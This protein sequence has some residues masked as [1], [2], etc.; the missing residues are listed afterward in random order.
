VG[1]CRGGVGVYPGSNFVHVDSR[2][3]DANW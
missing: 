1:V 2:G 3:Y